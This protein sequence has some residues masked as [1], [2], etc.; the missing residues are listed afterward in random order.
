[1]SLILAPLE[2]RHNKRWK[3]EISN[4]GDRTNETLSCENTNCGRSNKKMT[5]V[6]IEIENYGRL[7]TPFTFRFHRIWLVIKL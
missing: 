3:R 7:C 4:D 2:R 1:M 5:N 6:K